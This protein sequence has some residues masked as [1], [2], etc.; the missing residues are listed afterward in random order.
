VYKIEAELKEQYAN[1]VAK[2]EDADFAN[3]EYRLLVA[4]R[5]N[6]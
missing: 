1:L 3:D 2:N 5:E 6:Y 4:A